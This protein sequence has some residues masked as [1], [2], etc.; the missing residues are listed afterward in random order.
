MFRA[1]LYHKLNKIENVFELEVDRT[2]QLIFNIFRRENI[3][4]AIL[5]KTETVNTTSA[6][7]LYKY[8]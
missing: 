5:L 2:S 4:L 7:F 1:T 8:F 6:N 3:Y